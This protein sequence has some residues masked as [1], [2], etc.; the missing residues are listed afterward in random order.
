MY[1]AK[2]WSYLN[3]GDVI[4]ILMKN[5]EL[6]KSHLE[7]FVIKDYSSKNSGNDIKKEINLSLII[8]SRRIT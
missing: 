2:V 8:R 4:S 7:T 3:S 1:C 5:T 6:F